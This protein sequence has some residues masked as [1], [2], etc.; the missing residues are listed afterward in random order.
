[1]LLLLLLVIFV[2]FAAAGGAVAVVDRIVER[3]SYSFLPK[4]PGTTMEYIESALV[5]VARSR[6]PSDLDPYIHICLGLT[7]NLT[8]QYTKGIA[9]FKVRLS[10]PSS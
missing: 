9:C 10:S 5:S 2:V 1:M 3:D 8:S 7:Y 4:E 6:P